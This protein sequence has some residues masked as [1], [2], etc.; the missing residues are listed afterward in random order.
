[1]RNKMVSL[2]LGVT[3]VDPNHYGHA[4]HPLPCCKTDAEKMYQLL[5]L[6]GYDE[7]VLFID[8]DATTTNL[9]NQL[10]K[11]ST[12]LQA[13]DQ[14]VLT[15]SGHGSQIQDLNFDEESGAD[16]T[17]CLFDRQLIDD[18]LPYIWR[19]FREG[20]RIFL[21]LDSCHSGTA[22]KEFPEFGA[23]APTAEPLV[24]QWSKLVPFPIQ[25][26]VQ[27]KNWVNVYAEIAER[28]SAPVPEEDIKASILQIS[29]CQDEE[30][31]RAGS[32][33]S[34]F[35]SKIFQSLAT[36][37]N[38][39]NYETLYKHVKQLSPATQNP[40]SLAQG[41]NLSFFQQHRPFLRPGESYPA[42]L[43]D[44]LKRLK[45]TH[46]FAEPEYHRGILVEVDDP[47]EATKGISGVRTDQKTEA[48]APDELAILSSADT[49]GLAHPWDEAYAFH[50]QQDR[51]RFC[52]P[53]FFQAPKME[54]E[55]GSKPA[56]PAFDQ[57]LTNWPSPAGHPNPF[58]WHLDDEFSQ[59]ARA[60]K[61]VMESV[62]EDRLKVRI[63]HIDTGFIPEHI[64]A[65]GMKIL[66]PK[67]FMPGEE[68]SNP[69][70]DILRSSKKVEQDFHGCA[71][72]AILAGGNVP[73]QYGYDGFSGGV[74]GAAPFAEVVPMRISETVALTGLLG[75]TKEFTKALYYAIETGCEVV[76][77]S[78]GGSPSRSWAK[79]INA[80]YEA[81]ITIVAAAGNSWVKGGQRLL[82]RRVVYP[83]FFD[84]VIA[85]TGVCYNQEPYLFDANSFDPTEKTAGGEHMQGN[86]LPK[87]AMKSAIA[88]YTPNIAWAELDDKGKSV[89]RKNGGGTSSA[90]PQVAAAAALWIAQHREELK[91]FDK[92]G[93]RWR[94]VEAVKHALFSKAD[95]S[96]PLFNRYYGQ[97]V[98]KAY[99]ALSVPVPPV[100]QLK[101]A[102]KARVSW[103]GLWEFT[104]LMILRK[105]TAEASPQ[106][107]DSTLAEMLSLEMLQLLH[108]D[109]SLFHYL[110]HLD[111]D[112]D[113]P[114]FDHK[115][116]WGYFLRDVQRSQMASKLLKDLALTD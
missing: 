62:P 71:T 49:K 48:I 27:E 93:E 51:G 2:H 111:F 24:D 5:G 46:A 60:R 81:G 32:F 91:P 29:A 101:K 6:F 41:Q 105:D 76:T 50:Q 14:L 16:Q 52:E 75:N 54:P 73:A 22:S 10:E 80:A 99:D 90:T 56:S 65:K 55:K 114:V 92:D 108:K 53:A 58:L 104:R 23:A 87:R 67:S 21:L 28:V 89:F 43:A 94:K 68:H 13:G 35:T 77:I 47:Q 74:L 31:A 106:E 115:E 25:K 12:E 33:L 30:V 103:L 45:F 11:W 42:D 83:A 20:V 86:H 100:E 98:L 109:P 88:A 61:K 18:E 17:W 26:E 64:T 95:K 36:H 78:M 8:D 79:A 4:L 97:G 66:Y 44:Q 72:L 1:M 40:N 112:Q 34:V 57:Y 70:R 37:P 102:P 15:Y 3:F 85:V 39:E 84:R 63:G 96:H 113:G 110:D 59:L 82:P 38:L 116:Q 19:Q 7:R 9:K 107:L 69:G